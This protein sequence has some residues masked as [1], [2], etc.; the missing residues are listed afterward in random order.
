MWTDERAAAIS[1]HRH[2]SLQVS[3]LPIGTCMHACIHACMHADHAAVLKSFVTG[4]A[5]NL[6]SKQQHMT[7]TAA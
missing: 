7:Q 3:Q 6:Q 2:L 4:A 5:A 1:A